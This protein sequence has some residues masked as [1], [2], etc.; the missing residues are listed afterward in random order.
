MHKYESAVCTYDRKQIYGSGEG[1]EIW[2]K[3]YT[4][5]VLFIIVVSRVGFEE[6][7]KLTYKYESD[8]WDLIC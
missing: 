5:I 7:I 2:I 1:G 3:Q 6:L 4:N 8:G